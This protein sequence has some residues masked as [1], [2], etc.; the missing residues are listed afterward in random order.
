MR[1]WRFVIKCAQNPVIRFGVLFGL[2]LC[3][4]S[5]G[6]AVISVGAILQSPVN[7]KN[8]P[9]GCRNA[10]KAANPVAAE[11]TCPGTTS[12]RPDHPTGPQ[13]AI[14]AFTNPVSVNTGQQIKVYVSTTALAY[15]L[16]VYRMGWYQ[17][18][19]GRL[20]L[21]I[22]VLHSIKQ[23][24]PT[25]DPATRMVDCSN[26]RD[27][28]TLMI[29]AT[30]VSGIY[31][32]KLISS[33]GYMRYTLFVVRNDAS[34]API[35]FQSSVLTYQAYNNWGDY[36][37]YL[38]LNAQHQYIS[39]QRAYVVSFDRPYA[40][41][42][43]LGDFDRYEYNLLRWVEREGYNVSYSTD[44]DADLNPASLLRHR[45]V[46][47]AG[48][49]EY[50]STAMRDHFTAARDAGVSLAFFGANDSYWH[51]RLQNSPLGLDREVVCY[52]SAVLDPLAAVEPQQTTVRWR[53]A[54]VNQPE[55]ALLGEM[56]NGIVAGAWPLVLDAGAQPW[57]QGTPL[58]VG[59]ALPD[60]VT[61]EFDGVVQNGLTPP[62]L[63]ILSSS[64]V[65]CTTATDFC[66]DRKGVSNAT[67]Y[68]APSG[69]RVFDAGT[70]Q[71]QW[72]LDNDSFLLTSTH[73]HYSNAGFQQFTANL[74]A[75]LLA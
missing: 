28:M 46:L 9:D 57:L 41:D 15:S 56:Y 48:H 55:N 36:S 1:F 37:L 58:Y 23:P 73:R 19:G 29:P 25:I 26:W 45:L 13:S 74:I 75:Y 54:P 5:S 65:K 6:L 3:L 49:D 33:Q 8:L 70:F 62:S 63:T 68:T 39:S 59:K 66:P 35:L 69:A 4:V 34:R 42:D 30:W 40:R 16:Q 2:L 38:G 31:V 17:G 18:L 43:G 12:W 47:I 50:W 72:G 61:G 11:N 51:I 22:P 21:T 14:E 7:S 60:L 10:A 24:A 52:K 53:D 64:S 71:W 20:L 67:L 44:V 32:V 27:P